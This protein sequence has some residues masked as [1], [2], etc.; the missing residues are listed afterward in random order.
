[1]IPIIPIRMPRIDESCALLAL[2]NKPFIIPDCCAIGVSAQSGVVAESR[3][4]AQ[5]SK[6]PAR[7]ERAGTHVSRIVIAT[8]ASASHRLPGT[9][10][11]AA[12]G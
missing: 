7:I 11:R 2:H 1:M 6:M 8:E 3:V 12:L 4:Q 9:R 10:Y 5:R